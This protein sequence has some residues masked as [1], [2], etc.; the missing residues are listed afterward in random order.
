MKFIKK[1]LGFTSD[2]VYYFSQSPS[3]KFARYIVREV[4]SAVSHPW[5]V[6]IIHTAKEIFANYPIQISYKDKIL[7]LTIAAERL[8]RKNYITYEQLCSVREWK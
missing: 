5:H 7:G 4:S 6:D 2:L 8:Y 1:A 3:I